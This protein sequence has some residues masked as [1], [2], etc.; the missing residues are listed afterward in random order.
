VT[1]YRVVATSLSMPPS[2]AAD[3]HT[4]QGD[5]SQPETAHRIVEETLDRFGR[6]DTLVNNA[7]IFTG[8]PFLDYTYDDFAAM[9]AVNLEGFFHLTQ[10][11]VRH[12]A[13]QARGHVVNITTSLVD[14]ARVASPSAPRR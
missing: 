12:M 4:V 3:V 1:C 8:K 5:I 7:G 2:H 9:T 11:V 6:I 10:R 13:E 14:R